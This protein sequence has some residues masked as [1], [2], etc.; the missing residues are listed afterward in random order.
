[1]RVSTIDPPP[2]IQA[3]RYALCG[4]GGL[5]A[6]CGLAWSSGA[7]RCGL[8]GSIKQGPVVVRARWEA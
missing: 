8:F 7:F 2:D 3:A 5:T 1:V 6:C 4:A